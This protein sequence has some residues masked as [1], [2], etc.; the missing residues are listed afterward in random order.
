MQLV[1][2]SEASAS[3]SET[4]FLRATSSRV[5]SAAKVDVGGRGS[6]ARVFQCER[7]V[8]G[9]T[10]VGTVWRPR[11]RSSTDR[12]ARLTDVRGEIL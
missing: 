12:C 2:P 9:R 5:D 6:D 1:A 8:K 11:F 4:V 7:D 10:V 3:T